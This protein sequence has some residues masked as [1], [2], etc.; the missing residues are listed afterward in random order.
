VRRQ[1]ALIANCAFAPLL[2]RE[3]LRARDVLGSALAVVGAATVVL[4]TDA[5]DVR[6]DPPALL[7]ALRAP[8][9]VG[10]AIICAVGVVLLAGLSARSR[11]GRP[12]SWDLAW[13]LVDVGVCAI[14]G[15]AGLGWAAL[16]AYRG[17]RR[18]HGA[19]DEGGLDVADH[20][21]TCDF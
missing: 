16:V 11:A 5:R 3:R 8:L 21:G 19:V 9:F 6:L 18:L 20:A 15:E 17:R 2:L 10:Y 13:V 12:G 7:A 1:F 14:F 4:A